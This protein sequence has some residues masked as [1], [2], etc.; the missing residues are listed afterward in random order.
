[1]DKQDIMDKIVMNSSALVDKYQVSKDGVMEIADYIISLMMNGD[2]NIADSQ[3]SFRL[4]KSAL[5]F[6]KFFPMEWQGHVNTELL[7]G[8]KLS[9]DLTVKKKS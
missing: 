9:K 3:L 2:L 1:M 6:Y 5:Q 7:V 8:V 4:F